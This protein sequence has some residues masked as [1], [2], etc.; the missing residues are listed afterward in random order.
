M[1]FVT[2]AIRNPVP[3]LMLFIILTVGGLFGFKS[4]GIQDRP[5]IALPSITVSMSY[6][7]TPPDQLEA[8]ITRKIED[9]V[10]NVVG[11]RHISS[12]VSQGATR[13]ILEF[14]VG[15]DLS[16]ALDDVRDAVTRIRPNLPADAMEPV[17][18]RATTAGG[19][20]LVYSVAAPD[21]GDEEL[22]WFVDQTVMR[23]LSAVA[24]VGRVG[25]IGGVQREIRVSLD[26]DRMSAL[27]ATASDVSRQ[28][29]RM[30]A[31]L[32]AG[33]GRIGGQEQNVRAPEHR[34]D[35]LHIGIA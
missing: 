15:S 30:Q 19:P 18:S 12:Q 24:G 6:A 13:T 17:I 31:D 8:E 23:Q 5:D 11:V 34:D 9:A 20:I 7:G 32:P 21:M 2:W 10:A 35:P 27:R 3:V 14:Q 22:S 28:L 33:T 4:L 25:R 29:K 16:Q 1:N 26:P